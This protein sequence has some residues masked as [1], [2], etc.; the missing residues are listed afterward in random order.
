[1]ADAV[2][3]NDRYMKA[4]VIELRDNRVS[5]H[6]GC[7]SLS[8]MRWPEL[9]RTKAS[10]NIGATAYNFDLYPCRWEYNSYE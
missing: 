2:V 3:A 1:L 7:G 10:R 6:A 9:A 4:R 8:A 5:G